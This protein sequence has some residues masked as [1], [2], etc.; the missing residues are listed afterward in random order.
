[1]A[2]LK[3]KTQAAEKKSVKKD[4]AKHVVSG[5]ENSQ[6]FLNFINF[7][8]DENRTNLIPDI[9]AKYQELILQK[10]NASKATITSAFELRENDYKNIEAE[11]SRML[12]K[13]ILTVKKI[14]PGLLSGVKVDVDGLVVDTSVM[15]QISKF[16][17]EFT[18]KSE[19]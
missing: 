5:T 8:I 11:L 18:L 1:M 4:V 6:K 9:F 15:Y 16:C 14:D 2:M 12:K 3:K 13:D 17:K 19:N 10:Q 7:V